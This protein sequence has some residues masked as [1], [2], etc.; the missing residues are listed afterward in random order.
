M[1]AGRKS[2]A[3]AWSEECVAKRAPTFHRAFKSFPA[4]ASASV[5][6]QVAGFG[7]GTKHK[8]G[9]KMMLGEIEMLFRSVR[10]SFE[11]G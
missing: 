1:R 6:D 8:V 5:E 11:A 7:S 3:S 2:S 4:D 10:A 9:C